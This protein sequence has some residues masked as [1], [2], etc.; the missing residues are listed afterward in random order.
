MHICTV[1]MDKGQ[2]LKTERNMYV[3]KRA[4]ND[5]SDGAHLRSFGIEFQ[6]E[7]EAKGNKRSQSVAILCAGLLKRGM[8]HE[9]ERVCYGFLCS[10]SATYDGAA[11]LWQ[12]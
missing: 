6:I 5:D 1:I 11:L 12:W 3:L 7:E 9:L 4:I 2:S 8:M 10:R